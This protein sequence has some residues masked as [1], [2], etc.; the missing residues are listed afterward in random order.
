ML[1]ILRVKTKKP[2]LQSMEMHVESALFFE[3]LE[4]IYQRV[5]CVVRPRTPVPQVSV[6]FRKY[7]NANSRIRWDGRRLQVDISDLLEGAP[8]P[9]HEALGYILLA[10]LF[11]KLP[12][13]SMTARYN[14]YLNR[15]DVR[16]TIHFIR[17]IRGRKAFAGARGQIWDLEVLF[18]DLNFRYF[19]GLMARPQLGWS[20]KPSRTTLG[21]YDASHNVIVLSQVLDSKRATERIVKF[22]LF[23]EMLHL[24]HPVEYG[25]GRRCVHTREFIQAEKRFEGYLAAKQ[26][27]KQFL[28][29]C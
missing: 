18:D 23:H 1:P 5:F 29:R 13:S 7:A 16:R 10:K 9:V 15:A 26:E 24:K 8:A 4:H 3:N 22:V 6:R 11:S 14:R 27:L 12:P 2:V 21:H 19:H 20:L 25:N 17:Q 28:A